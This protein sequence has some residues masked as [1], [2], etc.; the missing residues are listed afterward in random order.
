MVGSEGPGRVGGEGT[1]NRLD[2]NSLHAILRLFHFL[3]ESCAYL[4]YCV[5]RMPIYLTLNLLSMSF[6]GAVGKSKE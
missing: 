1:G 5:G 3:R 4:I 2:Q 6:I